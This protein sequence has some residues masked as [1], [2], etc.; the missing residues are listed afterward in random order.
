MSSQGFVLLSLP[1]CTLTSHAVH[2]RGELEIECVTVLPT[3]DNGLTSEDVYL[4]LK[5][6]KQEV[7]IEPSRICVVSTNGQRFSFYPTSYD[8]STLELNAGSN[9]AELLTSILAEYLGSMSQPRPELAGHLVLMNEDTGEVVGQIS[10]ANPGNIHYEQGLGKHDPVVVDI[11][12]NDSGQAMEFFVR[13]V[14]HNERDWISWGAIGA[15]KVITGGTTLLITSS[16]SSLSVP[17]EKGRISRSPSPGPPPVPGRFVQMMT[18]PKT[19]K[20]LE[21]A[22]KYS[23]KAR[24]GRKPAAGPSKSATLPP[25]G[26]SSPMSSR[27]PSYH[28]SADDKPPLPPRSFTT[29][30]G[31]EKPP[32]PPRIGEPP[33]LPPRSV[34]PM[35]EVAVVLLLSINLILDTIDHNTKRLI[36]TGTDGIANAATHRYGEEAGNNTRM[37]TGTAKN[38]ALVYVDVK[39]FTHRALLKNAGKHYVKGKLEKRKR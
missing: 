31:S 23:G 28:S 14:P 39:G 17:D 6:G 18:S 27:P 16:S 2:A 11:D 36:E 21:M 19:K 3:A 7:P 30:P 5:C 15:S 4:V 1:D 32:L 37:A 24:T 34:S 33:L 25:P 26:F 35:P 9:D 38:V 10:E 12:E 13:T 8:S 22:G 29:A 20:N